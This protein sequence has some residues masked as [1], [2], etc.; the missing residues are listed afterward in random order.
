MI[1]ILNKTGLVKDIDS[2]FAAL[3]EEEKKATLK[4]ISDNYNDDLRHKTFIKLSF[5][6][7]WN[8]SRTFYAGVCRCGHEAARHWEL[9]ND[10]KDCKSCDCEGFY[11]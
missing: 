8:L 9:N 4:R 11:E 1:D 5:V 10:F 7:R 3:N 6:P 2:I